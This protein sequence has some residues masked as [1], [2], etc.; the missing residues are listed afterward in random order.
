MVHVRPQLS[1]WSESGVAVTVSLLVP[2]ERQRQEGKRGERET[3]CRV[4]IYCSLISSVHGA[5]CRAYTGTGQTDSSDSS[6]FSLERDRL[7]QRQRESQTEP[8]T[9][10]QVQAH[11]HTVHGQREREKERKRVVY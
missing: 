4:A 7:V 1:C 8:E 5:R 3:G 2:E 9:A 11:R 10:G 6:T